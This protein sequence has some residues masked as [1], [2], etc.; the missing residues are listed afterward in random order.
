MSLITIHCRLI[1]SEPVRRH[2][3]HLMIESNT[4]LINDLLKCVSQHPDFGIW[5]RRG[6]ISESVVK[7]LCEPL[8][9]VYPDQ[10]GRFYASAI[11]MVTYIYESWLSLQQNRRLRLDGKQR[12]L[13]VVKS[14][15]ELLELSGSTLD[16]LQHRAQD[17]LSQR[18]TERQTQIA[19]LFATYDATNDIL[20]RCAIS[21]L[22]KNGCKIPETEEAPEKFA[23]RIHRKQKE[24]EQLE[25]Q[26]QARLPKG[27]DL[28]GEEFLETLEIATQQISESVTQAREWQA[29]LLTRPAF[30]PYPILYGSS[31]DIRWGKTANGRIAVSFNGIDK[32]LK[33]A[34]LDIKGWFKAHKEYPFRLYCDQRQLPFFR[35]FLEDWQAYQANKDT[36]P[37]GLLTLSSGILV[38]KEG[39]G[40]GDP[41]N[42][43]HLSLHCTFDTRLMTAEGTLQVQQEKLAKTTKS[44]TLKTLEHELT[45][46]QKKFHQRN[47]S[48]LNRLTNLP[49]RPSQQPYQGNPEILVGLSIGLAD[50]I[51]AAVVNGRTGEVLTYCT[52]RTLLGDHYHHLN[53]H[54]HQQKQNALQRHKNQKRGV[55]YQP[56]ESELGQTIDRLLA[57]A[58]IQLA[59]TYR[60]GS[61]MMPNLTHLRELLASEI[62]AKAEQKC[63]GSVEAQDQY[64]K[65]YRRT[66]HQWSYNR[67]IEAIHCKA[68]QLG[69]PVESGFQPIQF[70]PQKQARDL[71]I[72]VYHSR[73]I[74]TK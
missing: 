28:T 12:W 68:Q 67:L 66:I 39:E 31:T 48:T 56:S 17:I 33:A 52:P 5:Q 19:H 36:Y 14:D 34:D 63:S 15:A 51:T 41:W 2:L 58:I 40:K 3:W 1:A 10:P 45:D 9:L 25:A 69:I 18:N 61:I 38:W 7:G 47:A 65:E 42:V 4:P 37:A 64:A 44:L 62:Q 72:S 21:Y 6:T 71:A 32:Y 11:L 53:R 57:K 46:H 27:R 29:K 13:N 54:R 59:Q 73:A 55:T 50:P 35:R 49:S 43:N 26:L 20:S 74:T 8:K 30:L 23:H 60:A 16:A 70:N 22:L 24:I